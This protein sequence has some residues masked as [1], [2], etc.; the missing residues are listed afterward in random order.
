MS[1]KIKTGKRE[2]NTAEVYE[3]DCD[4]TVHTAG[5][6]LYGNGVKL[7]KKT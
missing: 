2:N 5:C 3:A 7:K 1:D 4:T 6:P